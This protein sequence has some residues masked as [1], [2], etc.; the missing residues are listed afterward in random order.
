MLFETLK[1]M[2]LSRVPTLENENENETNGVVGLFRRIC[3][4]CIGPIPHQCVYH[5]P[6]RPYA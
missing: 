3:Y 2:I 6:N 1:I 5:V 4:S